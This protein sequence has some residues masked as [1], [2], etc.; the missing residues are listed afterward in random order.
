MGILLA[1]HAEI[2]WLFHFLV[3]ARRVEP[4]TKVG[5][6]QNRRTGNDERFSSRNH[7]GWHLDWR[8]SV[9]MDFGCA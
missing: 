9:R 1:I 3:T 7:R 5:A 8:I 6:E 4:L 2:E